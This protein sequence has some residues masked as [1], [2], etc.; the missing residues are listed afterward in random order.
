MLCCAVLCCTVL[1]CAVL[2]F[3]AA[4]LYCCAVLL[5]CTGPPKFAN[6]YSHTRPQF[7]NSLVL[8]LTCVPSAVVSQKD[9]LERCSA[10]R[11]H[12]AM[13]LRAYPSLQAS[14]LAPTPSNVALTWSPRAQHGRRRLRCRPPTPTRLRRQSLPAMVHNHLII[15]ETGTHNHTLTLSHPRRPCMATKGTLTANKLIR[16]PL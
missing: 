16:C 14:A 8:E 1:C 2:C 15:V 4:A 13:D 5:R 11:I 6:R 7:M 9:P 10:A 12:M 3:A